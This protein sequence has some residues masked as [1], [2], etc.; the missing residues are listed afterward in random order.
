ME[1]ATRRK[2]SFKDKHALETLPAM[3]QKMEAEINALGDKLSD[4]DLFT[5]D[6]AGFEALT[7]R[8]ADAQ[9][10][11]EAAEMKWLEL[12]DLRVSIEG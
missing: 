12:E 1:S 11:L 8:L 9:S 7:D 6:R 4:G 5:R 10:A 2:L 3:I